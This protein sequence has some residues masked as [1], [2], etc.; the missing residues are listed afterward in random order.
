MSSSCFLEFSSPSVM[1]IPLSKLHTT[2]FDNEVIMNNALSNMCTTRNDFTSGIDE[3]L[4]FSEAYV[5]F[6]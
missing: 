6:G 2:L 5:K 1:P 3:A 4:H